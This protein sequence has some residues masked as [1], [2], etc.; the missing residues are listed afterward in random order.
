MSGDAHQGSLKLL[1]PEAF[2]AQTPPP[3]SRGEAGDRIEGT[4]ASRT[5]G[6]RDPPSAADL[7]SALAGAETR[8]L[9]EQEDRA[10]WTWLE[11]NTTA[12]LVWAHLEGAYS[13]RALVAAMHAVAGATDHD[14]ARI[15]ALNTHCEFAWIARRDRADPAAEMKVVP[16][17]RF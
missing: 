6:M 17:R 2:S 7:M 12:D 3:E 8:S 14:E 5:N 13:L 10:V 16:H 11:E 15:R 1:P 4:F 9:T